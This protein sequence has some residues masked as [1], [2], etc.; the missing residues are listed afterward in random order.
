MKKNK[1]YFICQ[2]CGYK[3]PKWVG[4]CSECGSWNSFVEEIEVKKETIKS[5]EKV[6]LKRLD[7]VE[8]VEVERYSSGI[9]EF[10]QVLGGGVVKGGVVLIGGEPGIG[11]STVMLQISYY[12]GN[13]GKKVF[14]FSG[15]ESLPQLRIRSE[16]LNLT[17]GDVFFSA[18]NSFEAIYDILQRK[19]PDVAVIDSIQTIYSDELNSAAGTVS[20]VKF[21]THKL[22]EVAKKNGISI[23]I[24]G[25]VTKDGVIAG[26][27]V[28]E[29]LVD[30]VL[31]FE[32][33]Y[34][35]GLRILRAVKNRFGS[36]NEIGIF[37][38]SEYGLVEYTNKALVDEDEGAS[39][40]AITVVM[41][42]SRAFLVEI[43]ALVSHTYF[44]Y[45][46]RNVTGFDLNRLNMLLAILEKKCGFNLSSCDVYLNVVGG[47]KITEPSVDLAVCAAVISSFKDIPLEQSIV[48]LGEV[49]LTGEI[50]TPFSMNLRVKEAKRYGFK[51]IIAK[52]NDISDFDVEVININN[53][54]ELVNYI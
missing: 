13:K 5:V 52:M 35:R 47:L 21:V 16:R 11:K 37:E 44:N 32:G 34:E 15:E 23:F 14:Y 49:G 1:T 3:T 39:G 50:R 54:N 25:Q 42:G 36:T 41:E 2:T 12:M 6:E 10:D 30:T 7:E 28:L 40:R 4:R 45:P 46:R 48:F 43:Q 20:Q 31:Y 24:I 22:V 18:T 33:D 53:I 26:P 27:K 29:H 19:R 17:K 9:K 38:M 8:G 51:K